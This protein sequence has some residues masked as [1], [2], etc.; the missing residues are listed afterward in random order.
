VPEPE[1]E[2]LG[3]GHGSQGQAHQK[4]GHG[5][6]PVAQGSAVVRTRRARQGS[7]VRGDLIRKYL[8]K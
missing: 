1:A 5:Q 2:P 3:E 8:H 6:N 7:D 4:K